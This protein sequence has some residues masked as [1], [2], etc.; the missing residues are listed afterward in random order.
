MPPTEQ[1]RGAPSPSS[2][3]DFVLYWAHW[4]RAHLGGGASPLICIFK[5]SFQRRGDWQTGIFFAKVTALASYFTASLFRAGQEQ[6]SNLPLWRRTCPNLKSARVFSL[7]KVSDLNSKAGLLL[8]KSDFLKCPPISLQGAPEDPKDPPS[9]K[10]LATQS[11][12]L[13]LA[14][15]FLPICSNFI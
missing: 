4:Q 1:A 14:C 5:Y 10:V 12:R 8:L 15:I 6:L 13:S 3:R 2:S 7:A 9:T 11:L